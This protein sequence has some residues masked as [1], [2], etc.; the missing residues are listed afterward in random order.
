MISGTVKPNFW[1]RLLLS[2]IAIFALPN[3]QSFEN[4]NNAENYSSNVSI[5]QALE[6]VKVA[7]EVQRHAIP[8]LQ[9]PTKLKNKLQSNR[10]F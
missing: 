2:I 3:A 7:R 10:T 1:S 5:Q 9:F 6:T 4:Q 8:Q